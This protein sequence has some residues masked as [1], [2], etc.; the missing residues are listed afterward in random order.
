MEALT[1]RFR[2]MFLFLVT[3]ISCLIAQ[4]QSNGADSKTRT[5]RIGVARPVNESRFLVTYRWAR[6][7]IISNLKNLKTD[8]KSSITIEAVPLESDAKDDALEEGAEQHCDYVL[9]TRILSFPRTG[10]IIVGP[11]GIGSTPTLA[12]NVDPQKEM[13]VDFSVMRPGHTNSII[14]GR[15]ATPTN[16]PGNTAPSGDSAFEDAANQIALRVARELR[17]LKPQID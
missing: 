17:K 15:T 8:R 1:Y 4:Q 16:P 14:D 11:S 7:Q 6:D 10:G 13:S 2:L 12:G 3:C 9:L 5:I